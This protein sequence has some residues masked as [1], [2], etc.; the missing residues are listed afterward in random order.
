MKKIILLALFASF[1]AVDS[2]AQKEKKSVRKYKVEERVSPENPE[3]KVIRIEKN[4]DGKVEVTEQEVDIKAPRARA[5]SFDADTLREY[6]L[7]YGDGFSWEEGFPRLSDRYRKNRDEFRF[8]ME[9]LAGKLNRDLGQF[10]WNMAAAEGFSNVSIFTNKPATHVLNL[11]FSSSE[12]GP[13]TISVVDQSGE[14]VAREVVEDFEGE[15]M[16]QLALKEGTKGIFFV[17]I[18]Q[19]ERA[20]SRRVKV[21]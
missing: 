12:N 17:I 14:R 6:S 5:F 7:P 1:L 2:S 19:G 20:I 18:S 10:R 11:R 3:K 15:Y 16:G 4:I 8:N 21:E 9:D 13:V